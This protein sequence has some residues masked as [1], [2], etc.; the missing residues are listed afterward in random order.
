MNDSQMFKEVCE[1]DFE[2]YVKHFLKVLE[3]ETEFEWNWHMSLLCHHC[4]KVFYGE[5]SNLD[6]N[7]PPRMLK[8]VIV[9][10]LFPTWVWIKDPSFKI[11]GASST[12]ALAKLF[13]IKRR[14]IIE[15]DAYQFYW[16]IKIKDYMNTV[17]KFENTDNGFMQ[18]VSVGSSII[19][20]GADCFDG[21]LK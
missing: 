2:F 18:S 3:P 17:N 5:I 19:G 16:P 6:I 15:S 4:E 13:N 12:N 7:I 10:V 20:Q 14:E 1:N 8:S 21:Q 11:I 9:S